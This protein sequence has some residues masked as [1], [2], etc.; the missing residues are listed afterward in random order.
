MKCPSLSSYIKNAS[1]NDGAQPQMV[2]VYRG[3]T[4]DKD[5]FKGRQHSMLVNNAG[6]KK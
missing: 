6:K 1:T 4:R 3:N 2:G 5:Q